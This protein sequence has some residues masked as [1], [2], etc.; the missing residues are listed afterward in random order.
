MKSC[1][2]P[3]TIAIQGEWGSGKT[4]YHEHGTGAA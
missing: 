4:R 3:L 1:E 2:T